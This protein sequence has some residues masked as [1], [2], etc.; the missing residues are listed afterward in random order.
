MK[1]TIFL[2]LLILNFSFLIC[3]AVWAQKKAEQQPTLA[4]GIGNVLLLPV[5]GGTAAE[6]QT[7]RLLIANLRDIN[8]ACNLID[9]SANNSIV[10][11]SFTGYNEADRDLLFRLANQYKANYI[12]FSN[13]QKFG[14]RNLAI[15]SRYDT[16]SR[17][18]DASYYLEYSDPVEAWVKLPGVIAN[19]LKRKSNEMYDSSGFLTA[20]CVWVRY[21]PG[22][23]RVWAERMIGLLI[24]DCVI[25]NNEPY[26][27][28][29]AEM[30]E[31]L[32]SRQGVVD[33]FIVPGFREKTYSIPNKD[34]NA[35][36]ENY[37]AE[38][39]R[40]KV[41]N[42]LPDPKDGDVLST[43]GITNIKRDTEF[44]TA[45]LDIMTVSKQGNRTRFALLRRY[46]GG[47]EKFVNGNVMFIDAADSRDFIRQMRGFSL[48]WG[49]G[50]EVKG[51]DLGIKSGV[52]YNWRTY[53]GEDST[54]PDIIT[55]T[56]QFPAPVDVVARNS[57]A[58]TIS[59]RTPPNTFWRKVDGKYTA[60]T[61]FVYLF[62]IA[63]EDDFA[64]ATLASTR[65]DPNIYDVGDYDVRFLTPN[66]RYY[67]WVTSCYGYLIWLQSKPSE[68]LIIRTKAE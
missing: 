64:K 42:W 34:W 54:I 4:T 47:N 58:T 38:A 15:I 14:Q 39:I 55:Y 51:Y 57:T 7:L 24:G 23:D 62:W 5:M 17:R 8:D 66:T 13:V 32:A 35:H 44:S 46:R 11:A 31:S 19:L 21:Q 1:R 49:S 61:E 60:Q 65:R 3:P 40:R 43:I 41:T 30:D 16:F 37:I 59:F 56:N 9:E 10:P 52:K 45:G 26:L 28:V 29:T 25:A 48:S 20:K 53:T 6:N 68:R 67:I 27:N 22:V 50:E 33:K 2:A 18:T 36:V 12:V 63:T